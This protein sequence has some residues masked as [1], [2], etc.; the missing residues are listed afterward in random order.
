MGAPT[1]RP[2]YDMDELTEKRNVL[3]K[4][5]KEIESNIIDLNDSYDD[6][7]K[8]KVRDAERQQAEEHLIELENATKNMKYDPDNE[9]VS[10]ERVQLSERTKR[11][12]EIIELVDHS[13]IMNDLDGLMNPKDHERHTTR[14][15][16]YED[17]EERMN[18]YNRL[19][20]KSETSLDLI[21]SQFDSAPDSV[22]QSFDAFNDSFKDIKRNLVEMSRER[23]SLTEKMESVVALRTKMECPSCEST[24]CI[25]GDHLIVYKKPKKSHDSYKE[26]ISQLSRKIRTH[27]SDLD[28]YSR[29]KQTI[30]QIQSFGAK[31]APST[32]I[33]KEAYDA[34]LNAIRD[35]KRALVKQAS[36]DK[37]LVKIERYR[38]EIEELER[39]GVE[40]KYDHDEHQERKG[41]YK[42]YSDIQMTHERARVQI[43]IVK[44]NISKLPERSTS[45]P[46]LI[47]TQIDNAL[48]SKGEIN[49]FL[50]RIEVSMNQWDDHTRYTDR[51]TLYKTE[52]KK[53]QKAV[54]DKM[55]TTHVLTGHIGVMDACIEA[56]ILTNQTTIDLLN[57]AAAWHLSRLFDGDVRITI[58]GYKKHA[59][60]EEYKPSMN[61]VAE[62]DGR[63]TKDFAEDFSDGELQLCTLAFRLAVGD[64]LG[65]SI[66]FIDESL[67]KMD[68]KVYHSVL[69]YLSSYA[70]KDKLRILVISHHPFNG[71]FDKVVNCT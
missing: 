16:D 67:N 52:K 60:K 8:A 57:T 62:F 26:Q 4:T 17:Y 2:E 50:K 71:V 69:N 19:L 51:L 47:K 55:K 18:G 6:A 43:K 49:D 31:T 66:L 28:M 1:V 5:K 58:E 24:L 27:Q 53:Y 7:M 34:S 14:V 68:S 37:S 63:V 36:N 23:D 20:R 44:H 35:H 54:K 56:E 39:K 41:L 38:N 11:W 40:P 59:T 45:D 15:D 22:F 65:R 33:P 30:G 12:E 46:E 10:K 42:L 48:W 25:D 9:T 70:K 13:N 32:E 21:R 3:S 64:L 29:Y 61:I